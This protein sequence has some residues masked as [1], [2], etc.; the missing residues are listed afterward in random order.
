MLRRIAIVGAN[1]FVGRH[2][3]EEFSQRRIEILGVVRSEEGA[4]EVRAL[5]GSPFVLADLE[6]ASTEK[7]GPVLAHCDGLVY[8]ASVSASRGAIDRTDPE[9]LTNV[10]AACRAVGVPR[11]V[12]FS[13][14][15]IAHYGMN[16][17]CTNPYFLAKMAGEVALFRSNLAITVFRPSYIFG[18]GDEFLSPLIGR[19][20]ADS[21]IEIPGDGRYRLQPISVRDAARAVAGALEG[22]DQTSSR[23]LDLV[24]PEIVPY[25][26]LVA[27]IA[28]L[29]GR[30]I[31]I[32]DRPIEE[33][34][35][36]A[37]TVGFFGLRA[38]DLACLLC[39]EVSDATAV[40]ALVSAPLESLDAM[41]KSTIRALLP[42][43]PRG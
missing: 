41:I 10:L 17:Y 43:T 22:T 8:T 14:L 25:C 7:L 5:G 24:G 23:V 11:F 21:T 32:R 42:Q 34:L 33:T 35:T 27:R 31:Q 29:S 38:H 19:I 30:T 37:R 13:G 36:L 4:S 20:A 3:I 28:S 1:G 6:K 39:D 12:F 40:K 2:L 9:G 26:E 18:K 16:P 15:G